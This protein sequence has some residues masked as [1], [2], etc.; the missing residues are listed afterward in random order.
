[1][2]RFGLV[3][4]QCD[5]I[6]VSFGILDESAKSIPSLWKLID[7]IIEYGIELCSHLN[8]IEFIYLGR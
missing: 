2:V 1:M 7:D 5:S 6:H 4:P 8:M 3:R